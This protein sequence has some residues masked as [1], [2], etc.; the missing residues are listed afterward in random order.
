M[1]SDSYWNIWTTTPLGITSWSHRPLGVQ[2]LA[3]A[4][5]ADAKGNPVPWNETHWVDA[6]FNQLLTQALATLDIEAR[7]AIFKNLE[8]DPNGTWFGWGFL[9]DEPMGCV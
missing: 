8:Q 4:Y 2:V 5:A 3:L 6:E 1:P 7:K 9:L